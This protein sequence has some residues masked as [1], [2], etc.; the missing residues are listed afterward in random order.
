MSAAIL[1][2]RGVLPALAGVLT[3]LV[4]GRLAR[5]LGAGVFGQTLAAPHIGVEFPLNQ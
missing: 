1:S 3:V 2:V 4:T 5:V